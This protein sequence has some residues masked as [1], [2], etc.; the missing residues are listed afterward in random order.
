M[1]AQDDKGL[2]PI[3]DVLPKLIKPQG[4]SRITA[5]AAAPSRHPTG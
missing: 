3:G 5:P 4:L 1:D 2:A